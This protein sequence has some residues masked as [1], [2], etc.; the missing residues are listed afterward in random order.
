LTGE[1]HRLWDGGRRMKGS[2][3]RESWEEEEKKK[4]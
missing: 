1:K 3:R 4:Y 2:K